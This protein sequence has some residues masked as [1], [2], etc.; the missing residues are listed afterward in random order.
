MIRN[1]IFSLCLSLSVLFLASCKKSTNDYVDP[2]QTINNL[3]YGSDPSE[4]M[5]LYLP[6]SRNADSTKLLVLIHGGA[7]TEGDK[8]DFDVYLPVLKQRLPGWAFANINYRLATTIINHFPTQENDMKLAVDFLSDKSSTYQF[9]KKFVFLGA[10]A[11]A[12][13]ALLQ[14]YKNNS[15][16]IEAVVDFYG[17]SDMKALYDSAAPGSINQVGLQILMNGT[18]LQNP[19]MYQSSSP[20]NFISAQTPPTLIL[21]GSA[22]LIVPVS[23]SVG[24]RH[25][26]QQA[27]IPVELDIY[28]NMGHEIW[29]DPIMND[30]FDKIGNFIKTYVH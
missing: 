11:G 24:L 28:P 29:P 16:H 21:H 23:E 12:H 5:D 18:P 10:S 7:W 30:A 8:K 1:G 26:L 19:S 27:G 4:T 3:S 6:T 25:Q 2:Y 22:D 15:P 20:I 9:S 14:A 13:M 17:P